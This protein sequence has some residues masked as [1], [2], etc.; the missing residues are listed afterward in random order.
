M[1]PQAFVTLLKTPRDF[2]TPKPQIT[3]TRR[4]NG[5]PTTLTLDEVRSLALIG[6]VTARHWQTRE[7]QKG[8][9]ATVQQMRK[10]GL[11][12]DFINAVLRL[13][14]GARVQAPKEPTL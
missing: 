3:F 6:A 11:R 8:T 14:A 12:P 7:A 2:S 13:T 9:V 5:I 1:T 4:D 10:Q